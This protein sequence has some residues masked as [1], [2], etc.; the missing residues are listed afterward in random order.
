MRRAL[1][2]MLACG[3]RA[4]PEPPAVDPGLDG[5]ALAEVHP[6]LVLP[7][8][9]V[10]LVG[11][12]FV[13]ESEGLARF[14]VDGD[15]DTGGGAPAA[16]HLELSARF[17]DAQHLAVD[18]A[19]L[20]AALG[21]PG[22]LTGAASVVIDSALDHHRHGSPVIPIDVTLVESLTP[23]L[24]TVAGGAVFVNQELVVTGDGFLLGGAE[25]ETR[26]VV[27]GCFLPMGAPPPCAENGHAVAGVEIAARP[28]APWRRD[29]ARF[30]FAPAIAG[31]HPGAF[32]GTIK[33]RNVYPAAPAQESAYAALAAT[34][35]RPAITAFSPTA[36]SLGQ[37]VDVAGGGF[38]G[39]EPGAVTLVHLSGT[40]TVEGSDT[41]RPVDLQLVPRFVDG[42]RLRYVLDEADELG[43]LIDL[44][45]VAGSFT[46]TAAPLVIDGAEQQA[47]DAATVTLAIA[48]VKQVVYLRFSPSY[49]ASLGRFGMVALDDAVRARIFQVA[50]RDYLGVNLEWRDAPPDDFALY[51]QVDVLGPDPNALG[52]LGYDNTPGKD[53]GNARL[54]D[55]IGGVNATT[56]SDGFP[57]YGGV[58]AEEFLGF[59][60]HPPSGV[61]M[62]P[63]ASAGFDAIFDPLRPDG[64]TPASAV[65]AA[66]LA[67]LG[68]GS[69]CPAGDRAGQVA[70]AVWALGNLIGS[71]VTHETGHSL[72]LANP[73][74]DGF[75]DTSDLPNRLMEG[76]GDRP[77]EE[78]A[79]L[80]GE[81]PGLFCDS[82][83]SYL[84][85]VL[86]ADPKT[87]PH[88]SRPP[89][90]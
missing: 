43:H 61:A 15:F 7:G 67:P 77:F 63:I 87:D 74:G 59:S 75:H 60:L 85:D 56:Q 5:L 20:W 39:G 12:D 84:Q 32:A 83:Y 29:Q 23:R 18:G 86:P 55:R 68:D 6:A 73:Y 88:L 42:G 72:G 30:P 1:L 64:G 9:E 53:V 80:A 70:C 90:D 81:G 10:D 49:R 28:A 52:L 62:S 65:E 25:G 14:T 54:F 44:R 26:A 89:C 33:L 11:A 50:R 58:F 13:D 16:V 47:G 4:A 48:H 21:G 19:G 79:E 41:P 24:D 2:C 82:E 78:R 17:V 22:R 46:G 8:T 27:D 37:Y 34:V 51:A 66:A 36:A 76:G 57:G 71:T 35:K 3:C 45:R 31:I 40:F 38:V 69:A